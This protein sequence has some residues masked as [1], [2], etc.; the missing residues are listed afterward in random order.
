M[1]ELSG[2]LPP[3][4][5]G[6]DDLASFQAC[7]EDIKETMSEID[8]YLSAVLGEIVSSKQ[9][10]E[11]GNIFRAV[12]SIMKEQHRA[13]GVLPAERESASF[14]QEEAHKL[15]P[16]DDYKLTE[17]DKLQIRSEGIQLGCLIVQKTKGEIQRQVT[18]WLQTANAWEAWRQLNLQCVSSKWRTTF[19]LLT[20]IMNISFDT[21][22]ASFWQQFMLGRSKW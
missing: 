15:Q 18:R 9:P 22:P 1:Q 20:R 16:I 5:G 10:I 4:N 17:A 2:I 7:L 3:N 11:E 12:R 8:A 6:T 21:Q 19:Q 14:R 13:L